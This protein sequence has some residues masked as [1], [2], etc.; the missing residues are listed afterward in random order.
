MSTRVDVAYPGTAERRDVAQAQT[1]VQYGPG[2]AAAVAPE[3]ALMTVSA[4]REGAKEL[5]QQLLGRLDAE[6]ITPP[7][8]TREG[9]ASRIAELDVIESIRDQQIALNKLADVATS[10]VITR[11]TIFMPSVSYRE[12]IRSDLIMCISNIQTH[13]G[14]ALDRLEQMIYS[15]LDEYLSLPNRNSEQARR[16]REELLKLITQYIRLAYM[17]P[18]IPPAVLMRLMT[19][20]GLDLPPALRNSL[21]NIYL[22]N[23]EVMRGKPIERSAILVQAE[24]RR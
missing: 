16:I 23:L 19:V 24:T 1:Q 20:R 8:P 9:E 5:I 6:E 7:P 13:L 18:E 3:G 10:T 15:L 12:Q 21:M 4:D 14:A 17:I 2:I 11:V 22:L